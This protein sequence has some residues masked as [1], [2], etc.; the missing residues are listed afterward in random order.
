MRGPLRFLIISFALALG[1]VSPVWGQ[2]SRV[3]KTNLVV[4]AVRPAILL[5]APVQA[6]APPGPVSWAIDRPPPLL[7]V[8]RAHILDR[9]VPIPLLTWLEGR[10]SGV[11]TARRAGGTIGLTLLF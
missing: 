6:P 4:S 5:P 1:A 10:V 8:A 2:H 7:S 3:Q 11:V 9:R